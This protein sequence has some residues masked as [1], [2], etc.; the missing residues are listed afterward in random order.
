MTTAEQSRR[1]GREDLYPFLYAGTRDERS[2]L[3]EGSESAVRKAAEI[4]ALRREVVESCTAQLAECASSIAASVRAGG[5][6]FTFGNGGSSADAQQVATCFLHPPRGHGVPALSL[7]NDGA[8]VTALGNDAGFEVIFA[9]QLAALG[10]AADI[11]FGLSTSGG[12]ANVLRAFVEARRLGMVTV[13]MAGYGGGAM[14]ELKEIDYLFV[15]PS[16]SVHRI[17]EVQTTLY[18]LLWALTQQELAS[19]AGTLITEAGGSRS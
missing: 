11:A 12:S 8:L 2:V 17:Q 14:A 16:P 3:A 5:R 13:G 18:H 9:R 4:M 6:L 19:Q 15:V 1:T 7:T 10:R